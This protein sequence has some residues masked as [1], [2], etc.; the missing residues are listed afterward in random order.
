MPAVSKFITFNK[1]H[2]T[3]NHPAALPNYLLDRAFPD[4]RQHKDAVTKT[5]LFDILRITG[6]ATLS[7]GYGFK[8]L[9]VKTQDG[10]ELATITL[11]QPLLF[12]TQLS[13]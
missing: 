1:Y 4:F 3:T 5:G 2:E 12:C 10:W 8:L 13:G 9:S 6:K 11:T 7:T